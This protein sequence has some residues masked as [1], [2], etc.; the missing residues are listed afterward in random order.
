VTPTSTSTVT[1]AAYASKP[2]LAYVNSY[3]E[4]PNNADLGGMAFSTDKYSQ[5]SYIN[6]PIRGSEMTTIGDHLDK[7]SNNPNGFDYRIDCAIETVGGVGTF[8]RTFA[9]VPRIPLSLEEYLTANPLS[10]GEYAPPSA[11]GADKLTFEY[12]GNVNDVTLQENAENAVT[13]MFVTGD[14]AG[15]G[16]GGDGARFSGA[17]ASDLLE[18]GWPLLDGA[19]KQEWPLLGYN[20]INVDNW[21]NWDV[22]ADLHKTAVRMLAESR[23]PMGEYSIKING[24]LDPTV[25]TFNPGDWC[26]IIINDDFIA[27]RLNSYLEPRNDVILRKIESIK[28]SVPNSPA[29]P[30][31]ITLNL[32]PEW[33]VDK[34]GQ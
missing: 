7:Y 34:S 17:A 30:E 29:F 1:T 33:D 28:V 14:G 21:G 26:Q 6:A 19:E 5:K 18:R 16:S 25:G 13:R 3:G 9:L 31:D 4:F 2:A 11:F 15:S 20:K 32:V 27:E 22:E 8:T 24:S 10:S 12:P 23:P